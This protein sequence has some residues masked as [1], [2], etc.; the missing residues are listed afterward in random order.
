MMCGLEF[1]VW[2]TNRSARQF[3]CRPQRLQHRMAPRD[4][5]QPVLRGIYAGSAFAHW[6]LL[7]RRGCAPSQRPIQLADVRGRGGTLAP[8]QRETLLRTAPAREHDA[9]QKNVANPPQP[10]PPGCKDLRWIID[11]GVPRDTDVQGSAAEAPIHATVPVRSVTA[12]RGRRTRSRCT[13]L[14]PAT[15]GTRAI[16]PRLPT[17]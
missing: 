11:R 3:P 6:S 7:R 10:E 2:V 14:E 1:T 15:S 8:W 4:G 17:H 9:P 13:W 5:R 12:R 16:V